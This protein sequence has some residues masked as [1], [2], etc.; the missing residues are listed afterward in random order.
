MGRGRGP[1]PKRLRDEVIQPVV[2]LPGGAAHEIR[3]DEHRRRNPALLQH[4]ERQVVHVLVPI[5]EGDGDN[6]L[7]E[8]AVLVKAA[9]NLVEADEA[10]RAAQAVEMLLEHR[11]GVGR[12][13]TLDEAA[14]EQ[15]PEFEVRPQEPGGEQRKYGGVA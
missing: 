5:V 14:E 10:E 6:G 3:D 15:M 9:G 2:D 4:R 12:N 7:G 13:P 11:G 1:A 8:R